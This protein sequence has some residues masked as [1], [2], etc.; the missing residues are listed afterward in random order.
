MTYEPEEGGP[1]CNG[2]CEG[3]M[4]FQQ[5]PCYCAATYAPCG[6]CEASRLVCS[7]CGWGEE[8]TSSDAKH[9]FIKAVIVDYVKEKV[10]KPMIRKILMARAVAVYRRKKGLRRKRCIEHP[11]P[12]RKK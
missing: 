2:I 9:E 10:I 3:V 5:E 4:V 12:W 8:E 1:C 7:A 6:A 11:N